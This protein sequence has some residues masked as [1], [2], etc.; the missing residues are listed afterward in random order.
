[1]KNI[2]TIAKKKQ[3]NE[4]SRGKM[5][6]FLMIAIF[7]IPSKVFGFI[8]DNF[9]SYQTGYSLNT[10]NPIWSE[11]ENNWIIDQSGCYSGKCVFTGEWENLKGTAT[12]SLTEDTINFRVNFSATIDGTTKQIHFGTPIQTA[13]G[14]RLYFSSSTQ[15]WIAVD[16][17]TEQNLA[18]NLFSDIWYLVEAEYQ[19]FSDPV[20][21]QYRL[22]IAEK[23]WSNWTTS[24]ISLPEGLNFFEI[25]NAHSGHFEIDEL[26]SGT[27][28]PTCGQVGG[29]STCD[30]WGCLS[31]S[32]ICCW[33]LGQCIEGQCSIQGGICGTSTNLF[34][35]NSLADCENFGGYW[36]DDYCW[37]FPQPTEYDWA[38]YYAEHGEYETS[39]AWINGIATT[40]EG[41]YIT[42]G[43]FLSGYQNIFDVN[44]AKTKGNQ[45]GS[46]IP[47]ARG[48]LKIIDDFLGIAPTI[49][50]LFVFTLLISIGVAIFVLIKAIMAIIKIW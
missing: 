13:F 8:S 15:N 30:F 44:Q 7:F 31:Y 50:S 11:T 4:I 47:M 2:L 6:I 43:S 32:D 10:Q 49:D 24:T 17:I 20:K 41:Y 16:N 21:V 46:A 45:L 48:Y 40:F 9:D 39:S 34:F 22:N 38:S 1:M 25:E 23:G 33:N 26:F 27:L 18:E 12:T 5:A 29:C 37:A 42:F 35:C 36:Y 19:T 14:F 28:T 3:N